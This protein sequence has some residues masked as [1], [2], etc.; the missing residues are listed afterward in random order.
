MKTNRLLVPIVVT[1][2]LLSIRVIRRMVRSAG[3]ERITA[4]YCRGGD[5]GGGIGHPWEGE[6]VSV[7]V[8]VLNERNR[9]LPCLEGLIAQGA[10][11]AEILVV[12]GGSDD[13]TQQFVCT[14]AQR[15][16]RVR[17]LDASP[18]PT[19]WNGK[20]WGLQVG[21]CSISSTQIGSSQWMQTFA[22]VLL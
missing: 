19:D 13:G 12:D 6:R 14:Y 15:D 10:E 9:L 8:P 3:G 1:Q 11:V 2:A 21:L 17:L 4:D 7:I 22:P 16:P 18:I 5:L 20:S